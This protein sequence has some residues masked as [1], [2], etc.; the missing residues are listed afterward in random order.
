[1]L[2]S[3]GRSTEV[4]RRSLQCMGPSHPRFCEQDKVAVAGRPL[5]CSLGAI[6]PRRWLWGGRGVARSR[7][8]FNVPVCPLVLGHNLIRS[9]RI[10]P[11][12]PSITRAQCGCSAFLAL[13]TVSRRHNLPR[14]TVRS[15][16]P[17]RTYDLGFREKPSRLAD[18]TDHID[19]ITRP[20]PQHA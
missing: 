2:I 19:P 9:S 4:A 10:I 17:P 3:S 12:R 14:A 7:V 1:M 15:L 11:R 20:P 6:F 8:D 18:S 16:F 5:H 13:H